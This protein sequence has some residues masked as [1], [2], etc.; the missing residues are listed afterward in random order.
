MD[1]KQT[2]F[3]DVLMVIARHRTMILW[4]LAVVSVASVAY[5]LLAP[6]YWTS[7]AVIKPVDDGDNLASLGSSLLG[8]GSAIFGSSVGYHGDDFV[9]IMTSRTFS[10]RVVREFELIDYFKIKDRDSLVAMEKALRKMNG[11]FMDIYYDE[12]DGTV[13]IS[14]TTRNKEL[15][16]NIA[17]YYWTRLD[18]YNRHYKVTKGGENRA[19]IEK[20]LREVTAEIDSLAVE[21]KTF[22]EK[23]NTIML[24]EQ[25]KSIIGI[26]ADL[27]A[28]KYETDFQLEYA[29]NFMSEKAM[30]VEKLREQKKILDEQ[31]A[32][33]ETDHGELKPEYILSLNKYPNLQYQYG[34]LVLELEVQQKIYEFLYPQYEQARIEELKD[35]PT[36]EVIDK[37]KMAG[38]RTRPKR[39]QLCVTNFVLALV[40]SIILAFVM[41]YVQHHEEK[42][43][44]FWD[45]LWRR[46][47][48]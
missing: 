39:A 14:I 28:Q 31:I 10:E 18:E 19:F 38:K 7:R 9:T 13:K 25:A 44:I 34:R 36:L 21:M 8:I 22:M 6:Q 11:R 46:R 26:Y 35:M 32:R 29:R 27:V 45:L 3:F 43:R 30:D 15:S 47:R 20:R 2:D 42:A 23:N 40:G 17:D 24:E 1:T 4:I 37:A 48:Q 33:M 5:A 12:D 41:E 16:R